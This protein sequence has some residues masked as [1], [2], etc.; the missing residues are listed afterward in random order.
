MLRCC[1]TLIARGKAQIRILT[2]L[3]MKRYK[4]NQLDTHFTFT[5][6]FIRV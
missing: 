6:T 1:L 2:N 5:F 4:H 3:Q